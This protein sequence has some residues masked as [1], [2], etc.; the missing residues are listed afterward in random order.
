M[1]FVRRKTYVLNEEFD[2]NLADQ[3]EA[4]LLNEDNKQNKE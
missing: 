4:E 1:N 3:I 2:E